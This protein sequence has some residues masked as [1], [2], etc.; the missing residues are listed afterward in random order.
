MTHRR[1][2]EV[3]KASSKLDPLIKDTQEVKCYDF[4]KK[5][6]RKYTWFFIANKFQEKQFDS[7]QFD[8]CWAEDLRSTDKH[9]N[10]RMFPL[11]REEKEN[12][13]NTM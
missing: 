10:F 3:M 13:S 9:K 12:T 2:T 11:P 8:A 1:K 5:K 7:Q 6:T 4:A